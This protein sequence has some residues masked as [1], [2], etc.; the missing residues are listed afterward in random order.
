MA[1]GGLDAAVQGPTFYYDVE[2]RAGEGVTS[3][4]Y[5]LLPDGSPSVTLP[6][7][8]TEQGAVAGALKQL[9]QLDRLRNGS[10][11]TRLLHLDMLTTAGD[12]IWLKSNAP[13]GDFI[14]AFGTY[15]NPRLFLKANTLYT[16]DEFLAIFRTARITRASQ[17]S[18]PVPT[19][20]TLKAALGLTPEE[21]KAITPI[22]AKMTKAKAEIFAATLK[23]KSDDAAAI[24]QI[25]AQFTE[26]QKPLL[27]PIFMAEGPN[28][29][30][31]GTPIPTLAELTAA[32]TLTPDEVKG[33][34]PMLAGI[35]GERQAV[36]EAVDSY[37]VERTADITQIGAQLTEG[38]KVRVKALFDPAAGRRGGDGG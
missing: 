6:A 17:M 14:Y 10:Y 22:L 38:Q 20:E 4:H 8:G 34:A 7:G 26:A 12:V 3:A 5:F 2:N 21:L 23:Y 28:P 1:G 19:L 24:A 37:R 25:R 36:A 30:N 15:R 27:A 16:L 33:I 9:V 29:D 31:L 13:G 32:L 11:E 18:P 35:T